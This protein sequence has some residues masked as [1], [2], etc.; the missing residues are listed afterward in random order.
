[1][2]KE[3][4]GVQGLKFNKSSSVSGSSKYQTMLRF[5]MSC[6]FADLNWN[7]V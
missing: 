7:D 3:I 2:Q 4:H 1:M 6:I 5:V